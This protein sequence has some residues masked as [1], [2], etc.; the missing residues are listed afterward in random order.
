VLLVLP[1]ALTVI[2]SEHQQGLVAEPEAGDLRRDATDVIIRVEDL[3]VIGA[4]RNAR[5]KQLGRG[6]ESVRIEVVE[7]QEELPVAVGAEELDPPAGDVL[8]GPLRE[9]QAVG[10][11]LVQGFDDLAIHVEGAGVAIV[12]EALVELR[13]ARDHLGRDLGAGA[14]VLGLE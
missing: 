7:P 10:P 2:R 4:T 12:I 11:A 13:V 1:Q 9:L 14:I 6:V 5:A 3:R 8:R